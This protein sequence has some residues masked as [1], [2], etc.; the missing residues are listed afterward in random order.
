L[1]HRFVLFLAGCVFA[2]AKAGKN[3]KAGLVANVALHRA[4]DS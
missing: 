3:V 4:E 2:D 1:F